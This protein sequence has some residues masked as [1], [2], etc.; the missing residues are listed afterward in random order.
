[1]YKRQVQGVQEL[2]TLTHDAWKTCRFLDR[3]RRHLAGILSDSLLNA[4][5]SGGQLTPEQLAQWMTFLPLLRQTDLT[6]Q[7]VANVDLT[8]A[9]AGLRSVFPL[10]SELVTYYHTV[11]EEAV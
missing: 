7:V 5:E 3:A 1:M 9:E 11:H 8:L 10:G 4:T 2:A 6:N